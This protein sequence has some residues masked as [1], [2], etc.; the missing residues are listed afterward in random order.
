[1]AAK[2]PADDESQFGPLGADVYFDQG[3]PTFPFGAHICVVEVD[4]DTGEVRLVRHVAVDDCGTVL[5][6]PEELLALASQPATGLPGMPPAQREMVLLRQSLL[7]AHELGH[8]MGFGHN[9]ASS[10]NDRAS[11]ME[12]PTPRVKVAGRILLQ[13]G[14]DRSER[15][16]VPLHLAKGQLELRSSV[17]ILRGRLDL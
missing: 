5:H 12:Y 4:T 17:I 14:Q 15:A 8:V 6:V 11:V 10:I 13:R 3:G 16:R 2:A 1:M 9:F 7:T